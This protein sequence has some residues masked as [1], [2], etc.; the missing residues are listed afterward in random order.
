VLLAW[1]LLLLLPGSVASALRAAA[2][3]AFCAPAQAVVPASAGDAGG[4]VCIYLIFHGGLGPGAGPGCQ[5]EHL[6]VRDRRVIAP[7]SLKLRFE[8]DDPCAV[9]QIASPPSD[10]RLTHRLRLRPQCVLRV[11]WYGMVRCPSYPPSVCSVTE[12]GGVMQ[13]GPIR[14]LGSVLRV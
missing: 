1:L 5:P 12:G 11:V 13:R 4:A 14:S 2:A 10:L 8:H 6:F 9:D 7:A 3:A